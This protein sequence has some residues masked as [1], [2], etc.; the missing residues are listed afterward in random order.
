MGQLLPLPPPRRNVAVG[1]LLNLSK[2]PL[3]KG[4][5]GPVAPNPRFCFPRFQLPEVNS[6]PEILN[7]KIPEINNTPF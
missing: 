7:E 4:D 1:R 2:L 3:Q 6:S 5:D